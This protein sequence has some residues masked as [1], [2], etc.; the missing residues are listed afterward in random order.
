MLLV[1]AHLRGIVFLLLLD[2]SAVFLYLCRLYLITMLVLVGTSFK[3]EY[4]KLRENY[5]GLPCSNVSFD[6]ELVS[7]I[8][9]GL[10]RGKAADIDGLCNEHL[11]FSNPILP[12]ILSRLFDLIL[13]SRY[14]PLGFKWSYIVPIP[15]PRDVRTKAMTMQRL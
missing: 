10:K 3:A 8:V 9:L 12:V 4:A 2:I 7:K 5:C 15:K 14:I 13:R 1:S 11:I 6:T